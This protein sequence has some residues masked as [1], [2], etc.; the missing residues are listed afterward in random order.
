MGEIVRTPVYGKPVLISDDDE[1]F[2]IALHSILK[3]RLGVSAVLETATFDEAVECLSSQPDLALA[4]FDLNMPG[5]NNWVDLRTVRDCH[6]G[7]RVAV[8]SASQ[9]RHDIL[10]ALESGVHGY[11]FKGLGV[12]EL[13]LALEQISRG[14]VYI[15]PSFP[16]LPPATP[17]GGAFLAPALDRRRAPGSPRVTA[18]QKEVIE[19]LVA[20]KSNK[21]MARAL[22]LSEG[23]VKFHMSAAFR[24]LGA[25]NRVEA[26]TAGTQLLRELAATGT[27]S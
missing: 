16:D 18:R 11:V 24:L 25:A 8:V 12:T 14:V 20:G 4:L 2:R 15:P 27:A 5:M 26:A 7:V 10:M 22:G 17:G 1:F 6:P 9:D 21:A 23:T 3:D 13:G 19:L